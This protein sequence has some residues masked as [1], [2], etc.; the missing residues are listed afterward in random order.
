MDGN[1]PIVPT[2]KAIMTFTLFQLKEEKKLENE[3]SEDEIF[4]L[5]GNELDLDEVVTTAFVLDRKSVV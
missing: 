1:L 5:D 4:L 3:D 2:G